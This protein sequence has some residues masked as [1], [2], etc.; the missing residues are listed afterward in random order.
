MLIRSP[1]ELLVAKFGSDLVANGHGVD[2]DKL[3]GYARGLVR[4]LGRHDLMVVTSGAV[5]AG[6]A[7]VRENA[8]GTEKKQEIDTAVLAG[9]GSTAVMQAWQAAFGEYGVLTAGLLVTH[10]EIAEEHEG[11]KL[12]DT[13]AAS[14]ASGVVPVVNENDA[15]SDDELMKLHTGGD[16]DGLAAHL[17]SIAGARGLRLFT[18][19]GGLHNEDGQHVPVVDGSN[20]EAVNRM[21]QARTCVEGPTNGRGGM[22]SKVAAAYS[23]VIQEA[24]ERRWAEIAKPDPTMTGVRTTRVLR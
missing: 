10:H 9:I 12:R 20:I 8:R 21:L 17:A 6:R 5:A 11:K 2:T 3:A 13:L 1:R 4:Q 24:G 14:I 22:S 18:V 16:N 7:I 23:F 15:L 19:H